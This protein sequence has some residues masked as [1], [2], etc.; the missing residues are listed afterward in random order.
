MFRRRS[1]RSVRK[2]RVNRRRPY[3]RFANKRR[4]MRKANPKNTV[5]SFLGNGFP[6]RLFAKLKYSDLLTKIIDS[7]TGSFSG[8]S[9]NVYQSSIYD[10]DFTGTGH[11]PMYTDQFMKSDGTGPYLNYRVYGIGYRIEFTNTNTSQ[12][13]PAVLIFT[14]Q[15]SSLA[16]GS[17]SAWQRIEEQPGARL[18]S[19]PQSGAGMR[20]VK[21]YMSVAKTCGVPR[22]TVRSDDRY[23]GL[24]NTNP[25]DVATIQIYVTSGNVSTT[26]V[27]NIRV[28]L[29]YYV[30]FENLAYGVR[31]S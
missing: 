2:P 20:V 18:I 7:S 12:A 19:I 23:R 9:L 14:N 16:G 8:L 28:D 22:F 11:R 3:R 26:N 29:T 13:M 27:V 24:Y 5:A 1:R 25:A 10:P 21:G 31:N 17:L 30:E 15:Q 4:T 6:Q